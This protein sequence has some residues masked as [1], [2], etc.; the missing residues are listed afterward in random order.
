MQKLTSP[1]LLICVQA[2]DLDDPLM[3]FFVTWLEE[4]AKQFPKITVLA[5]RVGRFTLPAH[6][7]VVSLRAAGSSQVRVVYQLFKELWL[8]RAA[9]DGVF[10]RGDPH[11][12]ALAGWIWRLLGKKI[13]FWYSHYRR[14]W[15]AKLA[16]L[17]THRTVSSTRAA[18]D[19]LLRVEL[20]GQGIDTR[21][22]IFRTRPRPVEWRCLI[23]GRMDPA[24][25]V[26]EML[27]ALKHFPQ[28]IPM[29]FSLI[30]VSGQADYEAQI[31]ALVAQD[32]RVTWQK[33][34]VSYDQVPAL[35]QD[36]DVILNATDG[37]LDKTLLEAALSGVVPLA[38][39]PALQEWLPK[40]LLWLHA[41]TP[42]DLVTSL[43]QLTDLSETAYQELVER[44]ELVTAERYS[45]QAQVTSLVRVFNQ[46]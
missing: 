13:V 19:G 10:V 3:G 7:E 26:V 6:V 1:T 2:L 45:V 36:Y 35:Y 29:Q 17:I 27:E 25:R 46:L 5:L 32:T 9:Y 15:L 11:Y 24:K 38:T 37:S 12:V 20:I 23:F 30:G 43:I 22:F 28:T 8:R 21:R 34:S 4:A 18:S 16:S 31:D 14:N 33:R 44:V 42:E 41:L 39:T 40:D